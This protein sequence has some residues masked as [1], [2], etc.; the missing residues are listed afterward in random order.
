LSD[1]E[2]LEQLKEFLETVAEEEGPIVRLLQSCLRIRKGSNRWDMMIFQTSRGF[3]EAAEMVRTLPPERYE[4]VR[5][6]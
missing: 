5:S 1:D 2:K 3:Q 6:F 4:D